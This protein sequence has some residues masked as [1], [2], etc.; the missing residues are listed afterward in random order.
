MAPDSQWAPVNSGHHFTLAP[1]FS[2][3]TRLLTGS[4]EPMFLAHL[5]I[6]WIAWQILWNLAPSGWAYMNPYSQYI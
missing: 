6:T 2:R 5:I 4:H 3:I 1:V